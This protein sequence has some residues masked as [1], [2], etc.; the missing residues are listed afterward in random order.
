VKN[1]MPAIR[2]SGSVRGA[3]GNLLTYSTRGAGEA[4]TAGSAGYGR[5]AVGGQGVATDAGR[6]CA[7]G[8]CKAGARRYNEPATGAPS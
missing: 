1:R 8:A 7:I 2:T 3:E 4:R 6:L 5:G